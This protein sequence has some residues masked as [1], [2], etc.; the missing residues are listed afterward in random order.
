MYFKEQIEHR[1]SEFMLFEET[2]E[3][4]FIEI[5]SSVSMLRNSF[6]T[7]FF[8]LESSSRNLYRLNCLYISLLEAEMV[9]ER[10]LYVI[11]S[12]D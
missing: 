10:C 12:F 7:V 9:V 8:I 4:D 1:S 3:E 2:G 6:P 11:V 5:T